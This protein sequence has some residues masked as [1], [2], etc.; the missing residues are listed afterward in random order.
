[1]Y[2]PKGI[3]AVVYNCYFEAMVPAENVATFGNC[4]KLGGVQRVYEYGAEA[5]LR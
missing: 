4:G 1:M 2:V 3:D 5:E